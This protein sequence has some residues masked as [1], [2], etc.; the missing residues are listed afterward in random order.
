[1]SLSAWERHTLDSIK[2]ELAASDPKLAALLCAFNR[3]VSGEEMPDRRTGTPGPQGALRRLRCAGSRPSS[4]RVRQRPGLRRVVLLVVSLLT[5]PA[6]IAVGLAL[7]A[8]G[9]HATCNEMIAMV[10]CVGQSPG[11][12]PNYPSHDTTTGQGAQQQVADIP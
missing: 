1:M 6:L 11:H 12:G 8:G 10:A 2:D 3:L 7:N 4:R 9:D 5:I